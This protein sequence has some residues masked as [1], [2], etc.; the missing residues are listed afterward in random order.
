[1]I[2]PWG[3]RKPTSARPVKKPGYQRKDWSIKK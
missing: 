2:T 3:D 1:M